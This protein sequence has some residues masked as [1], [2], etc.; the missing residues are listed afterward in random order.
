L[1]GVNTTNILALVNSVDTATGSGD[2]NDDA[3]HDTCNGRSTQA[4]ANANDLLLGQDTVDAIVQLLVSTVRI[5]G[6]CRRIDF[7]NVACW[8]NTSAE[9]A[10]VND[11]ANS[12]SIN[13]AEESSAVV[14]S[15]WVTIRAVDKRIQTA[16]SRVASIVCT[17]GVII[18]HLRNVDRH[19]L[20]AKCLVAAIGGAGVTVV[21]SVKRVNTI[22]LSVA[23]IA[24]TSIEIVAVAA[25]MSAGAGRASV[26]SACITVIAVL[27]SEL[28]SI[29]RIT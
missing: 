8:A 13:A 15:A 16:S 22:A 5:D 27:R 26:R 3:D 28:A 1:D 6:I 12:R 21:T 7:S 9:S 2:A 20:A 18:T 11:W 14:A 10:V 25:S 17:Q 29:H 23:R 4:S 19:M 24:S